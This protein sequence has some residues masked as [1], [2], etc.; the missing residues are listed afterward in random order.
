[1]T[2]RSH[3]TDA[4]SPAVTLIAHLGLDRRIRAEVQDLYSRPIGNSG[5]ASIPRLHAGARE[6]DGTHTM[7]REAA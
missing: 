2:S 4:R 5:T 3:D 6:Q 7:D 1:M